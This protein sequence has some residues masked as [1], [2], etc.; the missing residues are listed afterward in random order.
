MCRGGTTVEN[1]V[2]VI[3]HADIAVAARNRRSMQKL[4]VEAKKGGFEVNQHDTKY[5]K[6]EKRKGKDWRRVPCI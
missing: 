6:I 4:E 5:I 3:A 1:V 2:Q